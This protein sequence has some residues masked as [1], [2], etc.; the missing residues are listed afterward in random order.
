MRNMGFV[1]QIWGLGANNEQVYRVRSA[2]TSPRRLHPL[3]MSRLDRQAAVVADTMGYP[4]ANNATRGAKMRALRIR[5]RD[6][7]LRI[8]TMGGHADL[9]SFWFEARAAGFIV[10]NAWAMPVD[11]I[12]II[13]VIDIADEVTEL[14]PMTGE[15]AN[16]RTVTVD[17]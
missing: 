12:A 14:N 13:D 9:P 2:Q 4:P 6:G 8:C 10:G 15:Q 5:T 3:G 11:N 16:E 1:R 7:E 17:R